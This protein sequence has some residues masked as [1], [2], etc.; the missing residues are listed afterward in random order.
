MWHHTHHSV[1]NAMNGM[2]L[3]A[4]RFYG[5][6]KIYLDVIRACDESRSNELHTSTR[7]AVKCRMIWIAVQHGAGEHRRGME[8]I[9]CIVEANIKWSSNYAN[10]LHGWNDYDIIH[11]AHSGNLVNKVLSTLLRYQRRRTYRCSLV[12]LFI[13]MW[14]V[15]WKTFISYSILR[16]ALLLLAA[17]IIRQNF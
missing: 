8:W 15:Y 6:I 1:W 4:R 9:D 13:W 7:K 3:N 12:R 5:I 17:A 10:D 2:G 11:S 14:N 16:A